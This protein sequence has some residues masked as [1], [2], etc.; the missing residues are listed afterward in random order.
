MTQPQGKAA[1]TRKIILEAARQVFSEHG[2]DNAPTSE[3]ARVAEC[4]EGTVFL[5]FKNKRGLLLA[6]M[7]DFYDNL[8][9]ESEALL[10][11][12]CTDS[13]QL[14]RLAELYLVELEK[15]WPVVKLFGVRARRAEDEFSSRFY[16][17][18]QRYTRLFVELF[19]QMRE[20]G[21]FRRSVNPRRLRDMLFGAIEHYALS[22]FDRGVRIDIPELTAQILDLLFYG[23]SEPSNLVGSEAKLDRILA[24]LERQ[25]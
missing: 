11:K 24:L 4:A 17:S 14:V 12:P 10:E 20:S 16:A 22:H 2:F 23:A 5:H 18:N 21:E 6:L 7:Q 3:V 15:N 9:S 19:E 1:R 13:Q 8:Q 25:V